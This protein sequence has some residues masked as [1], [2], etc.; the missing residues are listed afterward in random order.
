MVLAPE[1]DQQ[2][3]G[4]GYSTSMFLHKALYTAGFF[5]Y[6]IAS[7]LNFQPASFFY[8][9]H[10]ELLDHAYRERDTSVGL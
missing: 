6:A 1:E 3:R 5:L 4:R 2:V 10:E 8:R 7:A 9:H